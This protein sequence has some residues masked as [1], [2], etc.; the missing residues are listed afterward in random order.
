MTIPEESSAR[1]DWGAVRARFAFG[2]G[3]GALGGLFVALV[4]TAP[5]RLDVP[6]RSWIVVALEMLGVLAPIALLLGTLASLGLLVLFPRA[7][8]PWEVF[9]RLRAEPVFTRSRTAALAPLLVVG[10]FVW[11]TA[12]AHLAKHAMALGSAREAGFVIALGAVFGAFVLGSTVLALLPP[13]RRGLAFGAGLWGGFID[14]AITLSVAAAACAGVFAGGVVVGD[15]SGGGGVLGI[16]GVL[17][18][19]E[20]DLRPVANALLI[21]AAVYLGQV[22]LRRATGRRGAGVLALLLALAPLLFTLKAAFSL[23]VKQDVA[24]AVVKSAPLGKLSLGILRRTFDRDHDG[25]SVAFGDADCDDGNPGVNPGGLDIGGNGVDE[26][27]SGEDAPR[28]AIVPVVRIGRRLPDRL[29]NV[30]LITVDTLRADVGFLGYPRPV[31]PNLDR[32]AAES[33]VYE[34]AYSMASY[35]GKSVG[36]MLIGRYPSET[37]RDGSHFNKYD[38][39]N[40]FVTRRLADEGIHTFGAAG[41]WYFKPWSGLSQGMDEWDVSAIPPAMGDNDNTVNSQQTTDVAIRMLKLHA[42][43]RFFMWVHYFDP[44]AQYVLHPE[45]PDFQAGDNSP[46]AGTRAAYDSEVWFTDRHIGRLLDEIRAAPWGKDTAIIVTADHGEAFGEHNM[47]WHGSEIWEPLVHVPL[48]VHVPGVTP[49]RVRQK[50]SQI[51]I[52]PTILELAR[53]PIPTEPGEI[54]G[55]SLSR[56]FSGQEPEERNV[57]IDMPA[58][59]YNFA[60]R[61]ILF[62]ESPGMKLI[63]LGGAQYLLYDLARDPDEKNDLSGDADRLREGVS[64]LTDQRARLKEVEVKPDPP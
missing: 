44:H 6:S 62:G 31:T 3:G 4:E 22:T 18:R 37:W 59:P 48:L 27:C 15:T 60:R 25:Y 49:R 1:E 35:T 53:V 41:H 20:L 12:S 45:G 46:I 10:A 42:E 26:D 64:A 32:L 38:A 9:A 36:P 11:C 61:A 23:N 30:V 5:V 50:R 7:E 40:V 14:P 47:S 2:V 39:K 24:R 21:V 56:D 19:S 28:L 58:G 29:Y 43:R 57:Y 17:K 63:H 51:D 55:T 34:R 33:V 54:Q 8:L 13:L 16:Y 52:A